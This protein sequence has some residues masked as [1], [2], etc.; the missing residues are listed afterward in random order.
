LRSVVVNDP[1]RSRSHT[2]RVGCPAGTRLVGSTHA[3]AF[4]RQLPPPTQLLGTVR[5]RRT[6]IEGVVVARVTTTSAVGS[7]AEVQVRALC[8]G[9]R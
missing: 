4:R 2:V 6:V 9:V 1:V 8:A 3:I 7:Q 5:V